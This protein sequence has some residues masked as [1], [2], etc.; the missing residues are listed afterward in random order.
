MYL[1]AQSHGLLRRD[2]RIARAALSLAKGD[3]VG[4]GVQH[5]AGRGAFKGQDVELHQVVD[6]VVA[7]PNT[8]RSNGL[9]A[10]TAGPTLSIMKR[11]H[12]LE[13]G[14]AGKSGRHP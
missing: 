1:R 2:R 5:R 12:G 11:P 14:W 4:Y 6:L 13:S 10:V 3:L 8:A 9:N 7:L